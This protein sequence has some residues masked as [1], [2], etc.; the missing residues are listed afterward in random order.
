M[1]CAGARPQASRCMADGI[2][3]Q[4]F[5]TRVKR[6]GPKYLNGMG[7]LKIYLEKRLIRLSE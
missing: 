4:E 2:T 6:L 5:S 1:G 3:V 7:D